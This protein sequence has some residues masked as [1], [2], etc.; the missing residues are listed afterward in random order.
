[1]TEVPDLELERQNEHR[2]SSVMLDVVD[3]ILATHRQLLVLCYISFN[4]RFSTQGVSLIMYLGC[5]SA[6][7]SV[8]WRLRP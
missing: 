7:G 6:R 8:A 4:L 1:M 3:T 5:A 2:R